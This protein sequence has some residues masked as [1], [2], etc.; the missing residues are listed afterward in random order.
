MLK[1]D[2]KGFNEVRQWVYRNA[3]YIELALW[4]SEFENGSKEAV[5]D[6]LSFYQNEDGGFGNALEPDNWN[7]NSTPYTTGHAIK[8]LKTIGFL[9]SR[10]PILS[11]ILRFLDSGAYF[12]ENGWDWSIPTNNDYPHAPW[13][14]FERADSTTEFGLSCDIAGFI[15]SVC[16]KDSDLYNKAVTVI[17]NIIARLR[18]SIECDTAGGNVHRVCALA[19]TLQ[20][21]DMLDKFDASFLPE[22]ARKMVAQ[23]IGMD[24]STWD[25]VGSSPLEYIEQPDSVYYS[26]HSDAV[27]HELDRLIKSRPNQGVWGIGWTW[28]GNQEKYANAFAISENWWK[29]G[30]AISNMR[31]LKNFNR[32]ETIDLFDNL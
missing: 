31:I 3:R 2:A 14:N 17:Q 13:W 9:D 12:S 10:H 8:I 29:S 25:N 23:A 15:L 11:G 5:L 16:Q 6:A 20:K 27:Q 1:M 22:A 26:E 24:N 30:I 32:L 19:E 21:Y 7:P 28:Y 18:N 4:Q